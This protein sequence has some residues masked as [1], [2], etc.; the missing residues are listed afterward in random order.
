MASVSD[1]KDPFVAS[2]I[3]TLRKSLKD[4]LI[5]VYGMGSY[6]DDRLPSDW[7]KTDVDL[8]AIVKSLKALKKKEFTE[9]RYAKFRKEGKEVWIGFN[10]LEGYR[11]KE[12]FRTQS[13]SNYE[14]SVLDLNARENT[15]LLWGRDIRD[16][17]PAVDSLQ[18]D[19][20]DLLARGLYHL[21]KSLDAESR[22]EAQKRFTKGVFKTSFYLCVY[23]DHS[24]RMTSIRAIANNLERLVTEGHLPQ[25]FLD[26]VKE[27]IL[28]RRG[29]GF[30]A[31]FSKLRATYLINLF[32][33]LVK[34]RLHRTMTY[35][36]ILRYL[37]TQF[38]PF[39]A[40]VNFAE[41]LKKQR[42]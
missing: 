4:N 22:F 5:A 31:E 40:L 3:E 11:N 18:W 24:V 29:E 7:Q 30:D 36:E 1:P 16:T 13:F 38:T 33:L 26:A 41:T 39:L 15:P 12:E 25:I 35:R 17:L 34:G 32:V 14:W 9:V 28:F 10:T 37:K 2:I 42:N 8:I 6:F 20:D 19:F 23:L 27:S 21:D